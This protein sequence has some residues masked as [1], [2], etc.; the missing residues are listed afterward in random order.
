MKIQRRLIYLQK[1]SNEKQEDIQHKHSM[2]VRRRDGSICLGQS[3]SPS[4]PFRGCPPLYNI[5]WRFLRGARTVYAR[6]LFHT[7]QDQKK[8][9]KENLQVRIAYVTLSRYLLT[10]DYDH[11][12]RWA[13][14]GNRRQ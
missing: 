13:V 3:Q 1:E 6:L 7:R 9:M 10:I 5:E 11:V 2:S 14:N 12:C 4:A 8:P